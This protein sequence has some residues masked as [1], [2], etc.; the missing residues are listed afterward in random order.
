MSSPQQLPLDSDVEVDDSTAAGRFEVAVHLRPSSLGLVALG[1]AIGTAAR[2][3]LSAAYPAIDGLPVTTFGINLMGAFLLGV[4]LESLSRRGSDAGRRR[5]LRLLLG[6]GVMGG[7]TTYS[8]LSVDTV[9][10]LGAGR[11]LEGILYALGTVVLGAL[12]SI[13]GIALSSWLHARR[14]RMPAS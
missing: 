5:A 10:L 6:T 4:L 12:A 11:I 13:G 2:Y 1:G 7:F 3:L 8:A 14:R 9:T